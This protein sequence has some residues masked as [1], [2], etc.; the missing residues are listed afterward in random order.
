MAI[1][2]NIVDMMGGTIQVESEVG[3]GTEITVILE[4]ETSGVTV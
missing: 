2:K 4:C 1:T 3:K